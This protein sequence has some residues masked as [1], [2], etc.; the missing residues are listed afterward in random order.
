[1]VPESVPPF[2]LEAQF[3]LPALDDQRVVLEP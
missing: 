3:V 1:M 2:D